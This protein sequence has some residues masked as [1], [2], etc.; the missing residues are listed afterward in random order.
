MTPEFRAG[1]SRRILRILICFVS[2]GF[3]FPSALMDAENERKAAIEKVQ[4]IE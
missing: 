2:M 3:V 4:N 1:R